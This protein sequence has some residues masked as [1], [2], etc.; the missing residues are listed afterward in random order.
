[1]NTQSNTV[2]EAPLKAQVIAPANTSLSQLMY[3][4]VRRE[5]WEHRSIYIAPLA[6]AGILLFAFL[7][8]LA[9][10]PAKMRLVS[11]LDAVQQQTAIQADYMIMAGALMLTGMIVGT[12]YC[13]DALYGERRDRSILFWKSLPVSDRITVLSKAS[14]PL[15]VLPLLTTAVTV[16][17]Q[18]IMLL[19]S[20][21]VLL[22]SGLSVATLW[23]RLL[24]VQMSFGLLYHL[25]IVHG[26]WHAPF[27]G[28]LLMVSSWAKRAPFLWAVLPPLA[29]GIVEKIAF[30]TTYFADLLLYQLNGGGKMSSAAP[31]SA[32]IEMLG[33]FDPG[34]LL[35][36]L[37]LW[38]GLAVTA[39]FL[40]AAVWLRRNREPI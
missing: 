18:T 13:L 33:H 7:I 39:A 36:T 17:L 40:A 25:V 6:V 38:I 30:N 4:L 31:G 10:L 37:G 8:R 19:L 20:C 26:L 5:L 11:G 22:G 9:G 35:S 16:A 24:F 23:T 3:C 27:Y 21:A 12:F 1:M 34:T 29:L 28:W 14:I 15:F 2:H 32:P